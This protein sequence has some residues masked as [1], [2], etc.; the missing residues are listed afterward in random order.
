MMA[1]VGGALCGNALES[2]L[3]L[4]VV[5]AAYYSPLTCSAVYIRGGDDRIWYVVAG[6]V[7]QPCQAR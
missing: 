7:A 3:L 5:V 1:L 6:K 4:G 2:T